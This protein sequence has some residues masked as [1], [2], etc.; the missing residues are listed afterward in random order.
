M[1]ETTQQL[2]AFESDIVR[3]EGILEQ[4]ETTIGEM[5]QKFEGQK[6]E[7]MML[8]EALQQKE[9]IIKELELRFRQELEQVIK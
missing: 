8:I 1:E 5:Q 2:Q 7:K 3:V 4:K 6:R 9:T